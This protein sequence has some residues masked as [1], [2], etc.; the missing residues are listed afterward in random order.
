MSTNKAWVVPVAVGVISFG[1][2]LVAGYFLGKRTKEEASTEPPEGIEVLDIVVD[3]EDLARDKAEWLATK[4][5]HPSV[6]KP[7]DDIED[8]EFEMVDPPV[9]REPRPNPADIKVDSIVLEGGHALHDDPVVNDRLIAEFLKHDRFTA[10]VTDWDMEKELAEREANPGKPYVIHKDEFWNEELGYTQTSLG[11]YDVNDIL[12]DDDNKPIYNYK[13]IV[14]PLKWGHGSGDP[15]VF[16]VRNDKL[17][18]EY[19]IVC[20]RGEEYV[21]GRFDEPPVRHSRK[22]IKPPRD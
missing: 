20:Y 17:E 12:V 1:S 16:H 22:K 3:E 8:V 11:Y 10:P 14:G 9:P 5:R 19:E 13:R 2:G 18:A 21:P 7:K 4:A 15:N 6:P